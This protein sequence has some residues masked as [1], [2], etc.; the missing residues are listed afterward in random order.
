MNVKK[1]SVSGMTCDGCVQS[2][3]TKL[4][5]EDDIVSAE[6]S[7]NDEYLLLCSEKKYEESEINELLKSVGSYKVSEDYNKPNIIKIISK[8]LS[9]YKPI[10][11]TLIFVFL[12][13]FL[14]YIA[15]D[16]NGDSFM[17]FVMGYFF[18]IFHF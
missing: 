15:F 1:F 8:Y 14:S 5:L 11:I 17:R 18:L 10:L 3:K 6:V 9:T 16:G 4:E 7:L 13:S 12:L 2:I